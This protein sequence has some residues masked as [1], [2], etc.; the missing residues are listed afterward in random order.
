MRYFYLDPDQKQVTVISHESSNY[1]ILIGKSD[2][3]EKTLSRS[4]KNFIVWA[5]INNSPYRGLIGIEVC[6]CIKEITE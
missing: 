4:M 5:F 3:W 2:T 1:G 6:D